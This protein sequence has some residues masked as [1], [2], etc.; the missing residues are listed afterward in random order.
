MVLLFLKGAAA[1][2]LAFPWY[3]CTFSSLEEMVLLLL[4]GAI[5]PVLA[6]P[7]YSCPLHPPTDRK[8]HTFHI[9][10]LIFL[11]WCDRRSSQWS[12]LFFFWLSVFSTLLS[13]PA[14]QIFAFFQWCFLHFLAKFSFS[15]FLSLQSNQLSKFPFSYG[16]FFSL[17]YTTVFIFFS[18]LLTH[19]PSSSFSNHQ[20][21]V[22]I[23][24]SLMVHSFLFPYACFSFFFSPVQLFSSKRVP[25]IT[26]NTV[27]HPVYV[28]AEAI[29]FHLP[30]PVME[31]CFLFHMEN[32][33]LSNISPDENVNLN[34][35]LHL[36]GGE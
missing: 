11:P 18:I 16:V 31:I 28:H 7:W 9:I 13:S 32:V 3:N 2:L 26:L 1:P 4:K 24:L 23:F 5:V 10:F 36:E 8:K 20:P 15:L 35:E 17:F 6:F 22:K 12:P 30:K 27:P 29:S 33:P 21:A 14:V 25:S 19:A 34:N